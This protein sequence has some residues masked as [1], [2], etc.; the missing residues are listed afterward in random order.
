MPVQPASVIASSARYSSAISPTEEAL[1]RSGRS[2][3]TTVT[4]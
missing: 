3:E 2:F 1:M 4:S